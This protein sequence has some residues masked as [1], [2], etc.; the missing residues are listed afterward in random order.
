[1]QDNYLSKE[2]QDVEKK[3]HHN[4]ETDMEQH[5]AGVISK[6]VE[7]HKKVRY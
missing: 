1:M 6:S 3:T 4:L 7:K 2:V 5:L